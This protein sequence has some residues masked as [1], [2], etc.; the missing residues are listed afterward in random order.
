MT[1]QS[2]TTKPRDLNERIDTVAISFATLQEF[3]ENWVNWRE[4]MKENMT[5]A[6]LA[7]LER[8]FDNLDRCKQK[9]EMIKHDGYEEVNIGSTED[10]KMIEIGEEISGKETKETKNLVKKFRD[11][12]AFLH[13]DLKAYKRNIIQHTIPSKEGAKPL[14]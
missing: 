1:G 4:E 11:M 6:G 10:P 3:A 7:P 8:V 5:L 14:R 13:D 2:P 9:K 12:L